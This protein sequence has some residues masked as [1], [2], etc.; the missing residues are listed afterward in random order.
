MPREKLAESSITE[1]L[2]QLTGWERH[3]D[4]ITKTY[5]LSSFPAALVFVNTV[6]HLAEAM[7]H[8]PDILIKY[9]QVTFTLST[10]DA[11][12]LTTHDFDL[13][14]QIDALPMKK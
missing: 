9:R 8:H 3:G 7:D 11:G 2:N 1:R 13:A 10:H 6:G 4:E 14:V 5:K 12:G